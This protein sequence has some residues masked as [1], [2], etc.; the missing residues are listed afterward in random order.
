MSLPAERNATPQATIPPS[1]QEAL[2]GACGE[3][4]AAVS[5]TKSLICEKHI[6][7][8]RARVAPASSLDDDSALDD[9]PQVIDALAAAYGADDGGV[10]LAMLG[11][12]HASA[13]DGQG[14]SVED[15]FEE[16]ALLTRFLQEHVTAHLR[17]PLNER[18][19]AALRGS[20]Q[21]LLVTTMK[22][23]QA[24][25]EA[26]LQLEV[27]ALGHF[28]SSLAHDLRNEI[29]GVMISMQSLEE[30]GQ[31]LLQ[32][33]QAASATSAAPAVQEVAGL[34]G[35]VNVCHRDMEST[36]SAMTQLLEAERLRHPVM[37][38]RREVALLPLMQGVVRSAARADRG[39][40]PDRSHAVERIKIACPADAVLWTDPDLLGTVL[41]NFI[42]NAVKYAPE[43]EIHFTASLLPERRYAIS[44]SD[45]G[46]GIA[47]SKLEKLFEKFA[48]GR[49]ASAGGLGLGL[50]IARRAADLLEGKIRVESEP[51]HGS[52]F[53]LELSAAA[54]PSTAGIAG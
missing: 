34:L 2:Q 45:Q 20:M 8:L 27:T 23:F 31:Q 47:E 28:L 16:Y 17:R 35:E 21:A 48:R 24:Q 29:N 1:L 7:D 3:L 49:G 36:V 43:G 19:N 54:P 41:V 39:S 30:R 11:P 13:R 38:H 52:R 46:P 15:M 44:V 53:T 9:L 51:G 18:E 22:S 10:E 42:G 6:R 5:A 25:R 26:R 33:L 14:F 37:L 4:S 12:G 40:R 32:I 50:F